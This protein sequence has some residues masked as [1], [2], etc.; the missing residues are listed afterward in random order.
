M[1]PSP[2]RE[3]FRSIFLLAA[4]AAMIGPAA[5]AASVDE[6][7]DR[8]GVFDRQY[9]PQRALPFYLAAAKLEPDTPRV[10]LPIARQYRHLMQDAAQRVERLRLGKVALGYAQ[11]AVKRAPDDA[12]ARISVALSLGKMAPFMEL[13]EQADASAGIKAAADKAI[14]IDPHQDLAWHIV[15]RWH[16]VLAGLTGL[17]RLLASALYHVPKGSNEEAIRCLNRAIE[18]NPARPI[19]HIEL[20]LVYAQMGRTDEARSLLNKGLSM[21][22]MEK[23]DSEVKANARRVLATLH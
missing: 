9:Q 7:L 17:K 21:P 18:L 20:G 1:T 13:K 22:N 19:H 8:G 16:R 15:G 5:G 23:D 12:E 11:E 10:L 14:E 4:A 2:L 3:I 6:L